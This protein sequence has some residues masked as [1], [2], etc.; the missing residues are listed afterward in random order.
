V[1]RWWWL[2]A[3]V[4]LVGSGCS[5]GDD[6]SERAQTVEPTSTS[7][8][9]TTTVSTGV[10][11][12]AITQAQLE[13]TLLTLDDMPTGFSPLPEQPDDETPFCDG[14]DPGSE[15]P[16]LLEAEVQFAQSPTTGPILSSAAAAYSSPE[17]ASRYFDVLLD[18]AQAC[19][20]P[21]PT[22]GADD[23]STTSVAP[24]SF[25]TYGDETV[26]LRITIAGAG[27][28]ATVDAV[29]VRVGPVAF[30]SAEVTTVGATDVARL[31]SLIETQLD[32]TSELLAG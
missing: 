27:L 3:S 29:F 32:R 20:G 26:A 30:Q 11:P 8:D 24:L 14:R 6:G 28:P 22:P 21:Y 4:V 7:T 2:A 25:G 15:V 1:R 13:S 5:G 10:D 17:E 31:E 23:G 19:P 18:T 12:S 9:Q 16:E